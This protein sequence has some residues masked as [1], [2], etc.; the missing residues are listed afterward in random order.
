MSISNRTD[1]DQGFIH[2]RKAKTHKKWKMNYLADRLELDELEL[3]ES[4][5]FL[6]SRSTSLRIE[7]EAN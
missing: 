7:E 5:K 6:F 4:A 3:F 1:K 2:I